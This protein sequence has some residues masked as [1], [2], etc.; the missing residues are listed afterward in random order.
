MKAAS[1]FEMI[2]SKELLES[3]DRY[4]DIIEIMLKTAL[5]PIQS[6]NKLSSAK[7]RQILTRYLPRK[8]N[9]GNKVTS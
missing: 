1:G 9:G 8:A 2:W 5:N 4:A 3:M 6:T 7:D